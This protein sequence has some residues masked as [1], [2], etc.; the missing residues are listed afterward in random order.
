M[1][2]KEQVSRFSMFSRIGDKFIDELAAMGTRRIYDSDEVVFYQGER[3]RYLYGILE[4][5][6]YLSLTY[7]DKIVD[8][9]VIHE[10]SIVD[11]TRI[12]EKSIT[13]DQ[14]GPGDVI[15]WSA[16]AGSGLFTATARCRQPSVLIAIPCDELKKLM[17]REPE[18]GYSVMTG[19]A[20]VISRRRQ[21]VT[22]KL[23]EVWG[24][25][26]DHD[27]VGGNSA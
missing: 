13:L 11:R 7:E 25:Y 24:E 15:A 6:V 12:L 18:V 1:L 17:D 3:A 4:G 2:E 23:V 27:Q 14:L 16:L 21:S 8:V 22:E 10:E 9:D 20:D 19:L 26:F 5:A